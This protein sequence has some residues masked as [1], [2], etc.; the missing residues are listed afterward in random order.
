MKPYIGGPFEL[1]FK[2]FAEPPAQE[3]ETYFDFREGDRIVNSGRA[4]FRAILRNLDPA[5]GGTILVP[6]YLCGDALIPV[7]KSEPVS[8]RFYPVEPDF[9]VDPTRLRALRDDEDVRAVLLINYFGLCDV[10][11]IAR[12]I[13]SW[14]DP[15]AIVLDDVQ[16]M[17][18]LRSGSESRDWADFAFSSFRKFLALPDGALVCG[19]LRG[20]AAHET[21]ESDRAVASY[22]IGAALRH[23]F[24]HGNA[25][26]VPEV[27]A[28]YLQYFRDSEAHVSDRPASISEYSRQLLRRLPLDAFAE[29]RRRN[30]AFLAE[31]LE[32]NA[33]VSVVRPHP[34]AGAAPMALPVTIGP[35]RRDALREFLRRRNIFCPIHWPIFSGEQTAAAG[36]AAFLADNL[37]SLPIDQRYDPDQLG[38]LVEAIDE[39]ADAA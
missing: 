7:L 19:N 29:R 37:L 14:D 5:G 12:E 20:D 9:S 23:G 30:Y 31:A 13:R 11:E 2:I 17:W 10:A 39:F 28:A 22:V 24:L 16:A 25:A 36:G 27:E 35:A 32:G 18:D 1:D 34:V 4:A 8:Y 26:D 33:T 21:P 15:V 6:D 3:I 38:R